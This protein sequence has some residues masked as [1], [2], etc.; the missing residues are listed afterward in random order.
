MKTGKRGLELIKRYESCRLTAYHLKG[1]KYFTIGWGHSGPDVTEGMKITQAEADNL[2]RGDLASAERYVSTFAKIPLTQNRF[3]ALV[4]Y[5]Y[6]RGAGKFKE[7]CEKCHSIEEYSEGIVK[8]WGSAERYKKALLKRR[9]EEKKLFDSDRKKVSDLAIEVI[10]GEWGVGE[11]RKE[12]L[13]AAGYNHKDVQAEV[14][15]ILADD[16]K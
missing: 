14:N 10:S 13:E 1:E 11:E 12:R 15:R 16:G 5:C 4:S 8:Y 2:L 6:N 9:Y 7:Y 3:D